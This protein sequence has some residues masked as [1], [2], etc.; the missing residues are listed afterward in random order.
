MYFAKGTMKRFIRRRFRLMLT[1]VALSVFVVFLFLFTTRSMENNVERR[2][3]EGLRQIV[4]NQA[5]EVSDL[6]DEHLQPLWLLS[7]MTDSKQ[8]FSDPDYTRLLQN[9]CRVHGFATLG[10]TETDGNTVIFTGSE[11]EN[12][13]D[14]HFFSEVVSEQETSGIEYVVPEDEGTEAQLIFSIPVSR[15]GRIA[16]V[17]FAGKDLKSIR[18]ELSSNA[19]LGV[20]ERLVL[21][22]QS[23]EIELSLPTD[24]EAQAD[25]LWSDVY[26]AQSM[27]ELQSNELTQDLQQRKSGCL[28]LNYKG[29]DAY[30]AYAP[31]EIETWDVFCVVSQREVNNVYGYSYGNIKRSI[32]F[33]CAAFLFVLLSLLIASY[34]ATNKRDKVSENLLVRQ[35]QVKKL[36]DAQKR[37]IIVHS[38]RSGMVEIQGSATG[39]LPNYSGTL[40]DLMEYLQKTH[41]ECTLDRIEPTLQGIINDNKEGRIETV[42]FVHSN[43]PRW[44]TFDFSPIKNAAGEVID[45]IGLIA[46]VTEEHDAF[47]HAAMLSSQ[48]PSG[49]HRCYLSDPIHLEYVSE[50]LCSM[51]GYT[52]DEFTQLVGDDYTLAIDE[53]D[54]E[55]FE[56]FA[57]ACARELG[58]H[59]CEYKLVCKDGK[60]I[61]V[62]DTM[63][64]FL[65][66]DGT[67]RG[68]STVIDVSGYKQTEEQQSQALAE[69]TQ[70]L[71][72]ASDERTVYLTLADTLASDYERVYYVYLKDDSFREYALNGDDRH[73]SLRHTGSRFFAQMQRY[74]PERVYCD[75]IE[76]AKEAFRK[77]NLLKV[78]AERGIC[79]YSYRLVMDGK[80]VHYQAK[81]GKVKA[82]GGDI[83]IIGIRCR[84]EE[85][86]QKEEYQ[87]HVTDL[88]EELKA[89]RIRNFTS[90]MQPHF[91]YNALASIREIVLDNPQYASDLIYDFTTHLRSCV[92]SML[93]DTPVPFEQELESIKA[94]VNIEQMRF[95]QKLRVEYDI[96]H[97]EFKIMPLSIQPL[98][99]NA[100]RH[101]I[102]QR[103][104][105]GGT[106][107]II[108]KQCDNCSVVQVVDDGIGFDYAALEEE[109]RQGK[110]DSTGLNNLIFRL[111]RIQQATVTVHSEIGVGTTITVEIPE[112][113]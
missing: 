88:N 23:A 19:I 40:K 39:F 110:R 65:S 62:Y 25:K 21:V 111:Q 13:A 83:L 46:D 109:A 57:V 22:K 32:G 42:F 36:L 56:A 54:R 81:A 95:G 71:Q 10:Y 37:D 86:R 91:L 35:Q 41:P 27:N 50:S 104:V 30:I 106:V 8:S 112:N 64:S 48:V 29:R 70:E 47:E 43:V 105:L 45:V 94:Y 20:I 14:K 7:E 73:L 58:A 33:L 84:E 103:G 107:R 76:Y 1:L 31:T 11:I 6:I 108:T 15:N 66:G 59:T 97:T 87:K 89:A 4:L 96:D 75:D 24:H 38:V 53:E 9:I 28:E 90:Q 12:V 2:A 78:L 52:Y 99:E 85:V 98:V 26:I 101:G 55:K 82:D 61:P 34:Y 113:D 92:K 102:Y 80:P 60:R 17:L 63:A 3:K 18:D 44:L 51:L 93:S 67:I 79:A 100:I 49:I 69:M 72:I 77:K 74:I 5:H 16:G 68:V